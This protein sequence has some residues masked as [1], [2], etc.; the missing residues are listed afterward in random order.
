[1]VA[2]LAIAALGLT[3]LT[4]LLVATRRPLPTV[5]P[6]NGGIPATRT[7]MATA[8]DMAKVGDEVAFPVSAIPGFQAPQNTGGVIMVVDS[9]TPTALRGPIVAF[10]GPGGAADLAAPIDPLELPRSAVSTIT[11]A[12]ADRVGRF[13]Q[14]GDDVF[15][16]VTRL[17]SAQVAALAADPAAARLPANFFGALAQV[18]LTGGDVSGAV[19]GNVTGLVAPNEPLQPLAAPIRTDLFPRAEILR[20]VRNGS[21]IFERRGQQQPLSEGS[22]LPGLAAF[23]AQ[24]PAVEAFRARFPGVQLV[25]PGEIAT[26]E[27][28]TDNSRFF[29]VI[30]PA[31][32][33]VVDG[34]FG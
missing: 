14:N 3:G 30:D 32:G 6:V 10:V 23:L 2:P 15:V 17:P 33:R 18:R 4:G 1:M 12:P 7:P 31:T 11:A 9:V 24:Q 29:A 19:S 21:L 28:R 22:A 13:A 8:G 34:N 5:R 20:V 16:P 26:R 27:L 25:L